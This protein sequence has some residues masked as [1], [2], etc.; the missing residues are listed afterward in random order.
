MSEQAVT[1]QSEDFSKWYN[2]IVLR[3]DLADYAPVRG[4]M[5]I[6]PYG[7]A[8]WENIHDYLDR[9]FKETG[10]QNAYFPLL[11]P[12]SFFAKE[13]EH[14]EGFEPE[15]AI[16]TR[17]GGEELAERLII[18]PT[19]ETII[20]DSFSKWIYS[21]R[22]LPLL[23]NQWANVVRWEM[24]TRLFLRTL[25]FLWQE[26]HTA[27]ASFEEAQAEALQMLGIYTEYARDMA[28]IP[29]I[30]GMKSEQEKFAGALT[31]Y[32][33]EA[34][35][36][37]KKALQ[38]A[39]SHNLGQ[40]FAK[41]FDIKY[42]DVNNLLQFCWTTSWGFSTRFIGGIIMAHGDDKGL[43][44]PPRVAPIQ[45]IIVPIFRNDSEKATVFEY[46]ENVRAELAAA[47]VRVQIDKR[48]GLAPGYKYND[49]E[50]RGVPLR[51]EIGPK[52]VEKNAVMVAR[53]DTPGKEG[54]QSMP[55][56]GIAQA[57]KDTLESIQTG[58]LARA[59]EFR[60]A[61]IHPVEDTYD[62]FKQVLIDSWAYSWFCGSKDCEAKVKEDNQAVSRCFPLDQES[63]TGKC[64]VC[65]QPATRR[66]YFAK[67]Y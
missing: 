4:C 56:A 3:A 5:I 16:V 36:G 9:R 64:I 21:H 7:Y 15:L 8:L 40:N 27:H 61:N 54:K 10:H 50:M 23:I 38:A 32:T 46:A 41:S 51:L 63:G 31:T 13:A 2:E 14:I 20:G 29:V 24:R 11:I 52:D 35:M 53:R 37:D 44:L 26:G 12:E 67:A 22:D 17:G 18:R 25:E 42:T 58:M 19:S 49:W 59:T 66:A 65:D 30:P 6:K 28:A 33:I 47:G 57:I 55:R 39:T 60:D 48:E 45:A 62:H 43:R 34:M 1:P